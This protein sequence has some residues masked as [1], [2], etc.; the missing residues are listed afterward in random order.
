MRAH[1]KPSSLPKSTG[2]A[3]LTSGLLSASERARVLETFSDNSAARASFDFGRTALF[4]PRAIPAEPTIGAP[5]D[6]F[7]RDADSVAHEVMGTQAPRAGSLTT[8]EQPGSN[9]S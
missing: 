2:S 5:G 4:A 9:R 8:R 7:E 3:L 1:S 6:A